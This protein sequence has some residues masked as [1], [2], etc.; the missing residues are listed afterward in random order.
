MTILISNNVDFRKKKTS[1]DGER[2]YIIKWSLHQEETAILS[3]YVSN[4]RCI[5][6]KQLYRTEKRNRQI[7]NYY[8]RL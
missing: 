6:M 1:R 7:R 2:Y 8:W 4:K 3:M 5:N